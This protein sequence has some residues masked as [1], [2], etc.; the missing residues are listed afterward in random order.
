MISSGRVGFGQK[1]DIDYLYE[2]DRLGIESVDKYAPRS[3][4]WS[5]QGHQLLMRQRTVNH[6]N[7]L[8]VLN[9]SFDGK[10]AETIWS[11]KVIHQTLHRMSRDSSEDTGL[12]AQVEVTIP[13]QS[14]L[15]FASLEIPR[16]NLVPLGDDQEK[17]EGQKPGDSVGASWH[18]TSNLI[19]L[20]WD[21][22]IFHLNP[23]SGA[24]VPEPDGDSSSADKWKSTPEDKYHSASKNLRFDAFTRDGNIYVYDRQDNRE[25]AL[26]SGGGENQILNGV[27]PW[28]YWEELMWRSTYQ[29]YEWSPRSDRIAYFQFDESGID[30]YPIVDSSKPV[31]V[32]REMS[33]P[34]AGNRN[35]G[36]RL[37]I[38][39]LSNRVTRW[40][41]LPEL[42]EYLVHIYWEP[43]GDFL[44]VQ[45][46][47][48][49]QNRLVL[50]KV[51]P[52][53]A[54]GV[55]VLEESSPT[56]TNVFNMPMFPDAERWK[57]H[58]VWLSD[59]TGFNHLYL[60][61]EGGQVQKPLTSGDWEVMRRGFHG[62]QIFFNKLTDQLFFA[63]R[64]HGPLERHF[65]SVHLENGT[66]QRITPDPGN[67]SVTFSQDNEF[68]IDRWNSVDVFS[69]IDIR[70]RNGNL[71]KTLSSIS[72]EDFSPYSIPETEIV[73]I[74]NDKGLEFFGSITKPVDFKQGAKYPVVAYVYGEPAGQVVSNSFIRDW[75]LL[76]AHHGYVVFR[77]DARGTPGRGKK[78]LDAI[79][80]DQ[81]TLPMQDWKV[82]VKYLK[83][84]DYVDGSK[85]GVWGWSGGGTMTLNLMLR[86]PGLFNC[87]AAVAAVTDK[88]LY[89]T[90]Y[91]ER[92]LSTPQENPEGYRLSSPLHAAEN[93]QGALLIAHGIGDDNVHVQNAYNLLTHLNQANK[94]YEL[95][96][97]PEKG[98][99]I[100]GSA[101]RKHL[102]SRLLKFFNNHLK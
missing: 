97:Y 93:L 2:K 100:E 80:R 88:R 52:D 20:T 77:F 102:Y 65:Y 41:E 7:A 73:A 82:A 46:V 95:Y 15:S 51:N 16:P 24:V 26:T 4:S 17:G 43:S 9:I 14:K 33:Y 39:S 61:S 3:I 83:S 40:V 12:D 44:Y 79:Y 28:V 35:P 42:H 96:L 78:W 89:D 32:T 85:L 37:G 1:I 6:G 19:V 29:A 76:L 11:E 13:S 67:H 101:N 72:P 59:R 5:P 75:D 10:V 81:M 31:P 30:T 86:T 49:H 60:V 58:F 99:G 87:G 57:G 27:F 98:H 23:A 48:R 56:W 47:N 64:D 92:Y 68:F 54:I 53:S 90:I 62:K 70:D 74:T 8:V 36:I 91:T 69:Q 63:G 84:L 71:L 55:P 66:I 21:R 38:V 18:P 50:Y 34:K 25:L 45:G 22:K 94:S